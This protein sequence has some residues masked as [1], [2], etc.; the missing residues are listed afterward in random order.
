M[1]PHAY[2]QLVSNRLSV[3]DWNFECMQSVC[4]MIPFGGSLRRVSNKVVWNSLGNMCAR[5]PG[6]R[7]SYFIHVSMISPFNILFI[8]SLELILLSAYYR[9]N[10]YLKK[11]IHQKYVFAVGTVSCNL[12]QRDDL[13]K[14][15][16][17]KKALC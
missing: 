4:S 12:H 15:H 1:V 10:V 8:L 13:M 16:D 3:E 7:E 2:T 14:V 6:A 5:E 11:I 17:P 9:D